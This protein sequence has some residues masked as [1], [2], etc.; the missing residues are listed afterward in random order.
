M[1]VQG[2]DG[3]VAHA[4]VVDCVVPVEVHGA[5]AAVGAWWEDAGVGLC[6]GGEDGEGCGEGGRHCCSGKEVVYRR[7]GDSSISQVEMKTT[8]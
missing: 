6:G 5:V 7:V 8:V 3:G 1:D 2:C 4:G